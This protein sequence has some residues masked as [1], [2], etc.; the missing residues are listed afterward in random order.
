MHVVERHYSS[1][2]AELCKQF[3]RDWD[4]TKKIQVL[5]T[6]NARNMIS[7][8][9]QTGFALIPC[10]AH[11][12]QLSISHGFKAEDTAALFVKCRKIIG[13]FKHSSVNATE[14][15]NCNNSRLRKPQ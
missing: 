2:I 9:K 12:L 8:V 3:A 11:S 14:L 13:H 6:D 10:L 4:I 7:A 15:Q 1:N 5:V